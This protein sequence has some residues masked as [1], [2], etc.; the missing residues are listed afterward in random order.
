MNTFRT[1]AYTNQGGRK[2]NEDAYLCSKGIWTLADGLGGHDCGE[3]ASEESVRYINSLWKQMGCP[4]D[5]ESLLKMLAETN[6]YILHLQKKSPEKSSMRTTLVFAVTDGETLRYANVGDS[7]FYLFRDNKIIAQSEDHS[8]C[9][10]IARL[11]EIRY[12]DIR[13]NEDRNKLLKVIGDTEDLNI[14]KLPEPIVLKP[15]DAFLLCSDGF[16]EFVYEQEMEIDLSKSKSSKEWLAFMTKRLLLKTKNK[17]ND[18]FTAICV[19]IG[20]TDE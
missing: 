13:F 18:N 1:F 4:M 15:G 16:W 14:R 3:V 9:A 2:N 7:R 17:E 20:K 8:V 19:R 5:E 10:A 11:G 6:K 12:E